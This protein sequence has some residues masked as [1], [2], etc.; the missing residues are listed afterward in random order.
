M[1]TGRVGSSVMGTA[2]KKND[3]KED[4]RKVTL[5]SAMRKLLR[6]D[7]IVMVYPKEAAKKKYSQAATASMGEFSCSSLRST[8]PSA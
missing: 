6:T 8:S 7:G 2:M 3:G 4:E 1:T 5:A